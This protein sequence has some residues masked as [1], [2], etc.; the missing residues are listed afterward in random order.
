MKSLVTI[1][2]VSYKDALNSIM[3]VC[4]ESSDYS[5]RVQTIH[6]AAA[7]ALGYTEVQRGTIHDKTLMRSEEYKER[8]SVVGEG[9]AKRELKIKQMGE[10]L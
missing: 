6:M 10:T 9:Q 8:R 3:R 2:P 4:S 1:Y 5:R 7:Y